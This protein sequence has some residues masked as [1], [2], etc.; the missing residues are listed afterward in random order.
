MPNVPGVVPRQ[1]QYNTNGGKVNPRQVPLLQKQLTVLLL[2]LSWGQLLSPLRVTSSTLTAVGLACRQL[3]R[4]RLESID[5][6]GP[7]LAEIVA[8]LLDWLLTSP[9]GGLARANSTQFAEFP[10]RPC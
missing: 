3:V 5:N 10:F 4:K 8:D 2:E 6:V 9:L 7:R 1:S